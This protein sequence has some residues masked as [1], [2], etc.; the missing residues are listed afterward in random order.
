[1]GY[2]LDPLVIGDIQELVKLLSKTCHLAAY[3][4]SCLLL[5]FQD[6]FLSQ[7]YQLVQLEGYITSRL[8]LDLTAVTERDQVVL[9]Q[10]S[11]FKLVVVVLGDLISEDGL[12]TVGYGRNHYGSTRRVQKRQ[13]ALGCWRHIETT[14]AG[15]LTNYLYE[16]FAFL[17]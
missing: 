4:L 12:Q 16:F 7:V 14:H 13:F 9:L 15:D 6:E 2:S 17:S 8:V 5:C 1:V 10:A 11:A 3:L